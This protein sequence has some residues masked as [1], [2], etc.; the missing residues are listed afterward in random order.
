MSAAATDRIAAAAQWLV[1]TAERPKPLVPELQ[2][3]F[4][5]SAKEACAAIRAANEIARS[6]GAR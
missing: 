6:V 3:R 5:L 2:R 4:D 1:D